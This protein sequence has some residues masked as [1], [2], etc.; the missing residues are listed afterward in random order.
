[1]PAQATSRGIPERVI[2]SLLAKPVIRGAK[3][4]VDGQRPF[5]GRLERPCLARVRAANV[6]TSY[7]KGSVLFS[8]EEP[9]NGV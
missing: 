5:L 2:T 7:A 9:P 3:E 4:Y 6:G 8:Q 1:M